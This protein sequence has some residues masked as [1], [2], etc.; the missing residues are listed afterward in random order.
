[1]T[2][3]GPEERTCV[4]P[5][6][7]QLIVPLYLAALTKAGQPEVPFESEDTRLGWKTVVKAEGKDFVPPI[8]Y[9]VKRP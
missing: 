2:H 3:N 6:D 5:D 7:Q 9:Q 1:M 8:K 4:R